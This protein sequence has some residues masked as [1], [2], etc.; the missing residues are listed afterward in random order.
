MAIRNRKPMESYKTLT[1]VEKL[2]VYKRYL[3]TGHSYR[4]L[5]EFYECTTTLIEYCINFGLL[6]NKKTVQHDNDR[7]INRI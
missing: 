5:A 2:R 4:E 7:A 3:K 6:N 1:K